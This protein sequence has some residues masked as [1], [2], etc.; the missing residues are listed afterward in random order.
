MAHPVLETSIQTHTDT[1]NQ[2]NR[3]VF[4]VFVLVI[5]FC[6]SFFWYTTKRTIKTL[7]IIEPVQVLHTSPTEQPIETLETLESNLVNIPIPDFS[8]SL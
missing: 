1:K 4:W 8:E 5:T 2:K 7:P 6:F 3:M